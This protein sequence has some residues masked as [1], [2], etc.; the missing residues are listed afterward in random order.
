[1]SDLSWEFNF[2]GEWTA[3]VD[4]GFYR[5]AVC[6]DGTFDVSES[7]FEMQRYGVTFDHLADAKLYCSNHRELAMRQAASPTIEPQDVAM[8][9]EEL[10]AEQIEQRAA[11]KGMSVSEFRESYA[12]GLNVDEQIADEIVRRVRRKDPD[13]ISALP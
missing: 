8:P 2:A 3:T 9:P 10:T 13:T 1:M 6:D 5:V 12:A 7:T 4:D 11:D